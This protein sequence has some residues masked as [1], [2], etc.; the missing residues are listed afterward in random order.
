MD[1]KQIETFLTIDNI[2]ASPKVV[3]SYM[4]LSLR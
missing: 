1:F 3:K 2:K 4:C